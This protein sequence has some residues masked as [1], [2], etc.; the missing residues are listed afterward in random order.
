MASRGR[1]SLARRFAQ[2]LAVLGG[3]AVAVLILVCLNVANLM[4]ARTAARGRELSLRLALGASRGR[5]VSQLLVETAADRGDRRRARRVRRE[6][7]RAG[8]HQRRGSLARWSG[9]R[10]VAW[11]CAC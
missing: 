9:A 7:G 8:V 6:V 3:L 2:P 10:G 1:Q 5:I 11:T 4:L